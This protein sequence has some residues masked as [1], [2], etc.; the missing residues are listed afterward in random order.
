MRSLLRATLDHDVDVDPRGGA[1][2]SCTFLVEKCAP[3]ELRRRCGAR[4]VVHRSRRARAGLVGR[5]TGSRQDVLDR[6]CRGTSSHACSRGRAR[7]GR[8]SEPA[9][10]DG[11]HHPA[12]RWPQCSRQ[13]QHRTVRTV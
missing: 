8:P 13:A 7:G 11:V 10:T 6:P 9:S 3:S 1:S 5:P 2:S 12:Q 4:Q